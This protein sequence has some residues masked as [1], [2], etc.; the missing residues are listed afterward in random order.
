MEALFA[1]LKNQIG[2]RRLRLRRLK[3]VREQFF[4]AATVQN[5]KPLVRF[6]T[7]SLTPAPGIPVRQ[8]QK[9]SSQQPDFGKTSLRAHSFSTPTLDFTQNPASGVG[10]DSVQRRVDPTSGSEAPQPLAIAL[11]TQEITHQV[12]CVRDHSKLLKE[13]ERFHQHPVLYNLALQDAVD[14]E[15][16]YLHLLAARGNS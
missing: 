16:P 15:H 5:V 10:Y 7:Q 8:G 9:Q 12:R 2:M 1:E 13:A 11:L 4:L 3:F 6:L 14:G